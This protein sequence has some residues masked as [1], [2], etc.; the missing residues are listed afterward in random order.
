LFSKA[1]RHHRANVIRLK[2]S[3]SRHNISISQWQRPLQLPQSDCN[4]CNAASA[5]GGTDGVYFA[6]D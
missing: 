5:V 6:D 2:D 4:H 3:E 1:L